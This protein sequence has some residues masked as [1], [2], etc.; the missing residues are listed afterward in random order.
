M[1]VII[2][3]HESD[4]D[5]LG[6]VVLGNVAF[7]N[8]KYELAPNPKP[9]ELIFRK[10]LEEKKL[11]NYDLIFITDLALYNPSLEIVSKDNIL[12]KK[13][14]VF[15]HH[16]KAID[17]GLN[18]YDFV[19]IEERDKDNRKRCATEIFYEYLIN[20]KYLKPTKALDTFVEYTRLEDTWE[21]KEK[22]INEA[23][24]LAILFNKIGIED[25]INKMYKKLVS[26]DDFSYSS[27]ELDLINEKKK[28]YEE[29]IIEFVNNAEYF[30]DEDNNNYGVTIAPYQYRNEI[31]EYVRNNKKDVKYFIVVAL[32]KESYG[33]KSY[34]SIEKDFDVNV[35]A[36]KHNG[37]G[38]PSAASVPITKEQKE[39]FLKMPKKEGLE[40]LVNSSYKNK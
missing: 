33:Q 34:R 23:H 18:K 36:M 1:K 35:I 28:E 3:S 22:N 20:N 37:G 4:I 24:D 32:D 6:S 30:K 21:W 8:V 26:S 11:Y 29:K 17:E 14:H 27:E 5:G 25:Y 16:Q 12:S 10:Y 2:F 7:E 39:E 31:C 9:M 13:I 40:Y 15:D 19:F 38:H